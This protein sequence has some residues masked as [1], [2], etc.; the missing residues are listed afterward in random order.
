MPFSPHAAPDDYFVCALSDANL[1]RYGITSA[2]LGRVL[3]ADDKVKTSVLFISREGEAE[4]VAKQL[5]G[6]AFV[7][8]ETKDVPQ[9]VSDVLTTMVG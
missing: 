1:G 4:R 7:A 5:P 3:R 8:R 9:I 2:T 6:K